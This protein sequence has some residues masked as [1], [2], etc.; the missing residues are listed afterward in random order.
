MAADL[1]MSKSIAATLLRQPTVLVSCDNGPPDELFEQQ[2]PIS[3]RI[4]VDS[5]NCLC[6]TTRRPVAPAPHFARPQC[7]QDQASSPTGG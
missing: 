2:A 6:G 5:S 7:E 4:L 1:R 3:G